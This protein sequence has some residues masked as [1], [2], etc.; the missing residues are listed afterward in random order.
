MLR[1]T[2]YVSGG[3][4]RKTALAVRRQ[5]QEHAARMLKV[6]GTEITGVERPQG[7]CA[8]RRIRYDGRGSAEQPAPAGPAPDHGNGVAREPREPAAHSGPVCGGHIEVETGEMKVDR[9]LMAVD[10]GRVINTRTA[11]GQVEG[12]M[13]QALGF[14][15]SEETNHDEKGEVIRRM[16]AYHIFQAP[17]MPVMD[18]IFVETDEPARPYGAKSVSDLTIDGVAPAMVNAVHNAAVYGYMS[19]R[20]RRNGFGRHCRTNNKS[21]SSLA[22]RDIG[23]AREAQSNHCTGAPF[24][25][26]C[27]AFP[28]FIVV[29]EG[30]A[31]QVVWK[32]FG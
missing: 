19:Y 9:L 13:A 31:F 28:Y 23:S 18:V 32:K 7:D 6:A 12:G 10:C 8:R 21:I 27:T 15:R 4:V 3:A 17:Q 14:A 1:H 30:Q 26:R 11:A 2:T 24:I 29:R 16:G 5:V 25:E 20:S 22:E